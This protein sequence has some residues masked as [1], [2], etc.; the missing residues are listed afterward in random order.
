MW[1][2]RY[3]CRCD[4]LGNRAASRGGEYPFGVPSNIGKT[5][6]KQGSITPATGPALRTVRSQ[7]RYKRRTP[8]SRTRLQ[9]HAIAPRGTCRC[10]CG[11]CRSL[12]PTTSAFA[13]SPC[14]TLRTVS[15]GNMTAHTKT[16]A[17]AP[18]ATR[19]PSDSVTSPT[20]PPSRP[21]AFV[22][23]RAVLKHS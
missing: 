3:C 4:T 13:A 16:F 12:L 9:A 23:E 2:R 1:R 7:P 11:G 14:C 15:T 21:A 10:C 6:S 22:D 8:A 17:P 18:A 20:P 5:S 19:P